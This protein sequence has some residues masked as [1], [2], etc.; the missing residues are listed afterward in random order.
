MDPSEMK[1]PDLDDSIFTSHSLIPMEWIID[2]PPWIA[3]RLPDDIL[4]NIYRTKLQH[5]AECAKIA[6]RLKE[7]ESQLYSDI[8]QL[9]SP[10]K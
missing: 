2:P 3:K 1:L 10:G 7:V 4:V 9:M 6:T 8:A 5:R